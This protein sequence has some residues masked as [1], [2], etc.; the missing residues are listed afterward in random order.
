MNQRRFVLLDRDGTILVHHHYLSDP[1]RVQLL[2]GTGSA[3]RQLVA[4]GCGL[5]VITNQS[6]IGRGYFDRQRVELI[7]RRMCELLRREGVTLDGIYI[8]PHA[9]EDNC[10]CRKPKPGLVE[11]AALEHGFAPEESLVI[12]DN[13]CDMCLGERIGAGTFLVRTGYGA[14]TAISGRVN[15][16]YVVDNVWAASQI[17]KRLPSLEAIHVH[18]QHR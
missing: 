14:Y 9:P 2:P 16:N 4:C 5:L 12:G 6:G 17:I 3:L 8:C 7:H 13:V 15:P 10:R 1:A 18:A 11:Q